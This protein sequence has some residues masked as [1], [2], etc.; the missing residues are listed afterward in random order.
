[1]PG[2]VRGRPL[3]GG[4]VLGAVSCGL[5]AVR[6]AQDL[7]GDP[8][9]AVHAVGDRADRHLRG[10]EARPQAGEH[11]PADLAVQGA[12]AVDPLR[13]PHAHDGH[14]EHLRVAAGEGLG[15]ERQHPVRRQ[16]RV[17]PCPLNWRATRSRLNRSIPAG[18]GVCVVNTV[19]ARHISRASSKVRPRPT[20]SRIRSTPRKPA[21]PSLVWK[22]SG[23]GC[24]GGRAEG[25]DRPDAAD[26]QQQFLAQPVLA[27]AAVEPVG[28]LAQRRVVLLH[29]GVEQQQRDPA[30]L[31]DPD[32]R[33]QGRA[34]GQRDPDPRRAIPLRRRAAASAAGRSGRS[35]G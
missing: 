34:V 10:V 35:A 24:A 19:P 30:D 25:P 4:R 2:R 16:R 33:G 29:V 23:S 26:A 11:L 17:A 28:D 27:A 18:T 12:D 32:L 20:Y 22:T 15:A 31:R 6:Q 3:P 8:G 5:A 21:W 13:Q 14:V 7:G 9:R 1:M